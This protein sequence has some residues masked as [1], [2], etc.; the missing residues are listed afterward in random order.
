MAAA[1]FSMNVSP[2]CCLQA[3][4]NDCGLIRNHCWPDGFL[5]R[6]DCEPNNA[7]VCKPASSCLQ[8]ATHN[9]PSGDP[10]PSKEDRVVTKRLVEG[11]KLLGIQVLD[12]II[13]GEGR[14]Y[15]FAD[16]GALEAA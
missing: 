3:L 11:G 15:S 1:S 13:V 4:R 10:S 12:H 2:T 14:Y 9:H 5:I 16:D 6:N 8:V 7:L